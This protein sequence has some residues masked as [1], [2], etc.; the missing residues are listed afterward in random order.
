MNRSLPSHY[1][2]GGNWTL[3]PIVWR[4]VP[5][6]K[7]VNECQTCGLRRVYLGPRDDPGPAMYYRGRAVYDYEP[8][9]IPRVWIGR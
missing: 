3:T 2:V 7:R 8:K 5:W 6:Y 4:G 9:C 1:Y